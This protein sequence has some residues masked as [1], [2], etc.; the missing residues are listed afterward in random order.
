MDTTAIAL[1]CVLLPC[2]ICMIT[3]VSCKCYDDWDSEKKQKEREMKHMSE[4]MKNIDAVRNLLSQQAFEHYEKGIISQLLKIE[5]KR[6]LEKRN[7]AQNAQIL[8]N[9]TS[10]PAIL[11]YLQLISFG[12][13]LYPEIV[14]V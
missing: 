6:A 13:L 11:S 14:V 3:C 5:I 7:S 8:K 12:T 10:N 4:V 9:G 2:A 1:I